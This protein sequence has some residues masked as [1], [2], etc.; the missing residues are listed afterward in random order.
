MITTPKLTA[1]LS[2]AALAI[3]PVAN[4]ALVITMDLSVPNQVTLTSTGD[5]ASA[6]ISGGTF[7]GFYLENAFGSSTA[8]GLGQAL[9]SGNLTTFNNPSDNTPDLFRS[10]TNT[11]PGLNVW[12]YSTDGTSSFTSGVQ[13][14]SGSATWTIS[15]NA[16]LDLLAGAGSG[17]VY[18]PADDA[19]DLGTATVIGQWSTGIAPVIPEPSTYIAISGLIGLGG[20]VLIRRRKQAQAEAA[21]EAQA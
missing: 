13:A 10:G 17:N 2:I 16:Y 5:L 14:L 3:A 20:F 12:D 9:V 19:T 1:V 8:G 11:D 15:N 4:A 6:T 21:E 7:I 18:F